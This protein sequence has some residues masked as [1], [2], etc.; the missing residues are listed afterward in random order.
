[1]N[2]FPWHLI[3]SG[4]RF[5]DLV[6][7]LLLQEVSKHARIFG[8]S[9]RDYS[10]DGS[11]DG[12]YEGMTGRWR[13]QAKHYAG[14]SDLKKELH[15]SGAGTKHK[16]GEVERII[17]HIDASPGTMPHQLWTGVT[18]YRLL[19]SLSLLPQQRQELIGVMKPLVDRHIDVDI[20]DGT[21]IEALCQAKP[22][23][24]QQLFGDDPPLF[25]P[26]AEFRR[27][28]SQGP[29]GNFYFEL[30]YLGREDL[31]SRFDAFMKSDATVL[32]VNGTGGV[33]KT[34][35]L[36]ELAKRYD[37]DPG[38]AVRF[39]Q[40]ESA[41][42]EQHLPELDERTR[43]LIVLDEADRFAHLDALLWFSTKHRRFGGRVRLVLACRSALA[44]MIRPLLERHVDARKISEAPLERIS[45]S[46]YRL[47]EHLGH[48]DEHARALL[49][50]AEGIPLWLVLASEAIN[51]GVPY[52]E[53]T[54]ERIIRSH[55]ERYLNEVAPEEKALHR[56]LLDL[57]AAVEPV[58]VRD[59]E[60]RATMAELIRSEPPKFMRAIDD[61]LRSGFAEL[62]GR[63]LCI[64]PD[65]VADYLLIQAFFTENKLPT[66]FHRQL[67]QEQVP[68]VRRL[69]ANLARA[70]H[71]TGERLLD[72]VLVNVLRTVDS[73]D[74]VQR[75][76]L[77]RNFATLGYTRP[78]DF[79]A[80][81]E[82]M[83][84][85]PQPDMEHPDP[86]RSLFSRT[87]DSHSDVLGI[88][89]P[90]L[91]G[92]LH[93]LDC[94][95]RAL[96][97]L[98]II[99][100]AQNCEE[101]A[102]HGAIRIFADA[103]QYPLDG[104][105]DVMWQA[106]GLLERWWTE[107]KP[108]RIQV[109]LAGL[110]RMLAF[111][112]HSAHTEGLSLILTRGRLEASPELKTFRKAAFDLLTRILVDPSPEVRVAAAKVLAGAAGEAN[113]ARPDDETTQMIS[114]GGGA[115]GSEPVVH[116]VV[117]P[118]IGDATY[119]QEQLEAIFSLVEELI[120]QEPSGLVLE[121]LEEA[122]RWH[123][124]FAEDTPLGRRS[125][126][127]RRRLREQSGYRLYACVAGT[128]GGWSQESSL[129]RLVHVV[130]DITNLDAPED[131]V[132]ELKAIADAAGERALAGGAKL[133]LRLGC[134]HPSYAKR[135]FALIDGDK[136]GLPPYHVGSLV[137]GLR[138]GTGQVFVLR[139]LVAR[140]VPWRYVAAIACTRLRPAWHPGF[141]LQQD[142]LEII[143]TLLRDEDASV[144]RVVAQSLCLIVED[145]PLECLEMA[146]ELA[147][148]HGES[149]SE[150]IAEVCREA[151]KRGAGYVG[152]VRQIMDHLV[153]APKISG[154]WVNE[155]LSRLA[156]EDLDW[157]FAFLESR[158]E[159][160]EASRLSAFAYEGVPDGLERTLSEAL[161]RANR[162]VRAALQRTLAWTTRS[163][164]FGYESSVLV[165]NL[166]EGKTTQEVTEVFREFLR[167]PHTIDVLER[168]GPV[169]RR[170]QDDDAKF[171]LIGDCLVAAK[172][173]THTDQQRIAAALAGAMGKKSM[174]W[175]PGEVPP[176]LSNRLALLER[177]RSAHPEEPLVQH[178]AEQAAMSVREQIRRIRER[179]DELLVE[180]Q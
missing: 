157:F 40:I 25:I 89:P 180:Q 101:H 96:E 133:L 86:V 170:L 39:V 1:M 103:M 16:K 167:S 124:D 32:F 42:F 28:Q 87:M 79:L 20:W 166:V 126:E 141:S 102:G 9:G 46:A 172:G 148:R 109:I 84:D 77:L 27:Q 97:I 111:E 17:D 69:V 142:D 5:Q 26:V 15:G 54:K 70:E 99:A 47:V 110:A 165:H 83:L 173:F 73:Q 44:P 161:R 53:L 132:V 153:L 94:R 152:Q 138:I 98:A 112:T 12:T 123:G 24:M 156:A 178:F 147:E 121:Q 8:K 137:A 171:A 18:H 134:R 30:P 143:R 36:L 162:S 131:L 21:K 119:P 118:G 75:K 151:L 85:T 135:L 22:F 93:W 62:R 177:L 116:E 95:E 122:T 175:R 159:R 80:I 114:T 63:Y 74:N 7:C 45:E 55:I 34:R 129:S 81:V 90:L 57:L 68:D 160:A 35:A 41:G 51:N 105:F 60:V 19:T 78:H 168:L 88:I 65:L 158:I 108:E 58:N 72:E 169:L 144:R 67:L 155:V 140:T 6:G 76:A 43:H 113:R 107:H 37:D 154:V 179:D 145:V 106:L 14:F 33:G 59:A 23:L 10:I 48:R 120:E 4:E 92:P 61:V 115:D 150:C 176:A 127:I 31:F 100:V 66:D 117:I 91:A 64:S 146:A 174:S 130:S 49:Q 163:A 128:H 29:F 38:L 13:F 11:Y 125:L 136:P 56:R 52:N 164:R 139:E 50:L 104:T 82:R 3:D 2:P 149:C 71:L